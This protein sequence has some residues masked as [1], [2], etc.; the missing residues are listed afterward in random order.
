MR[1]ATHGAATCPTYEGSG[2]VRLHLAQRCERAR[3]IR[4]E[5]FYE[6]TSAKAFDK[7]GSAT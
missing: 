5:E 3:R 1:W 7:D 6:V 2:I 4:I